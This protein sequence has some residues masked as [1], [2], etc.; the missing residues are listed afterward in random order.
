MNRNTKAISTLIF[1]KVVKQMN[2]KGYNLYLSKFIEER[3]SALYDIAPCDRIFFRDSDYTNYFEMTKISEEDVKT[4]LK[5]CFF[6]PITAF[7]PRAVKDPLTVAQMCWLRHLIVKNANEKDIELAGIFLAFSGKFYPS[8]HYSSYPKTPP[9]QY[10]HIMEYVVNHM[11]TEKYEL[12]K[13]GTVIGCIRLSVWNWINAYKS[14]FKSFS[15][16][17]VV[18][19]VQQLHNRVKSFTKGIATLYYDA[20]KHKDQYMAYSSESLA[21]D[22]YRL[23]DNDSLLAERIVQKTMERINTKGVDYKSCL[24]CSDYNVRVNE[25]KGIIETIIT[26]PDE[27]T[28]IRELLSI[29]VSTY[30]ANKGK[31]VTSIEFISYSTTPKSNSKEKD[32]LR[33]KEIV[34]TWLNEKSPAYRK[35]NKRPETKC[36]YE[37]AIHSYFCLQIYYANK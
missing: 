3:H 33:G 9:N 17:D 18:Y 4:G 5:E 13:Q 34:E 10:R 7:H 14:R 37:R 31:D 30:F 36:S 11:L 24:S 19:M 26:N 12:K 28:T 35:R 32:Y 20:Y 1:P 8:I 27:Q 16:D 29:I 2:T 21:E 22:D 15:D 6:W 25:I 23:S